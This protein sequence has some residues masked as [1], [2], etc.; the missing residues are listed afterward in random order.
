MSLYGSQNRLLSG[1]VAM[2]LLLSTRAADG[3]APHPNVDLLDAPNRA[4]WTNVDQAGR[5]ACPGAATFT[6]P[7]G[8]RGW[9]AHGFRYE[10][11]SSANWL[12]YYGL[13]LELDLPSD[14]PVEVTVTLKRPDEGARS[15]H[16]PQTSAKVLVRG[17][18]VQ[19]VVL[20]WS[21]FDF[22][23]AQTSQ[24]KY[25]HDVR[26]AFR[27]VAGAEAVD[28]VVL[29]RATVLKARSVAIDA[30]IRGKPVNAG[31]VVNYPVRLTNC[32][33]Q[34]QSI[35]LSLEKRGW[36]SMNASVSP[37][38]L[39]IAPGE[40]A[41][42]TLSVSASDRVAPG[43][44]EQQ[45][46][47][48]VANG[49]ASTAEAVTFVTTSRL[50]APYVLHTAARWD[51]VRQKVARYDWAKAAANEYIATADKWV[52]PGVA[53]AP[54]NTDDQGPYLFRTSATE[55][56]L[57][58]CA[59]AYQVTGDRKYAEKV[60]TFLLRLSDPTNG[61]PV[62]LRAC[63]QSLVQE[64]GYFQGI[65]WS[66][67][68]VRPSGVFSE[69]DEAQVETT[70]R[71]LIET[72]DA[73][74]SQGHISNWNLAEIG[75][76]LF[77]SL[78][79]Q[80]LERADRFFAGPGGVTDHLSQGVMDDGWWYECSISYN[81]WCTTE[82]TQYA[83]AL[84]PF[85]INFRDM[86]LPAGHSKNYSLIPWAMQ[87]G[88][89]GMSFQKW[90]PVTRSSVDIRRMWDSLVP[91]ADYRAKM[92]GVNDATERDLGGG[93]Y[94]IA[95]YV[96]RDPKYAAMIK[97]GGGKRDLLYAVPELPDN[98]PSFHRQSAYADNVGVAMLRSTSDG[99]PDRE[100]IQA[101]LH[102]GTH[103][104]YHGHFD[105]TD[106]LHL[107]RYGR[108]FFNPEMVWYGYP[109]FLYKFYVQNSTS[110][111]MVVVDRKLQEP[112]ESKRTLWHNG[113]LFQATAVETN[114]RWSTPPYGGLPATRDSKPGAF[115]ERAWREGR[116]VATPAVEP[117][118]GSLNDF[119]EPVLQRRVMIVT[120]DY[121]LLSDYLKGAK[122]HTFESL[123]QMKGFGGIDGADVKPERHDAQWDTNPELD[124]QFVTDADWYSANGPTR[125]RF[126]QRWGPGAD[127][128]GTRTFEN[129]D[130]V[131][132]LDVHSLWPAKQELM[133]ATV[134]EPHPVEKR[135]FYSVKGD[136]IELHAGKFGAWVLGKD[137]VDVPIE[138]VKQ[139]EL[140]T[141]VEGSKKSTVFWANARVVLADGS[142]R[143]IGELPLTYE[144]IDAP[145]ESGKDYYG[146]PIKIVGMTYRD[147]VAGQPKKADAAGIVKVDLSS[148]RAVRFRTTLGGDYPL[149]DE[150]QRRKTFASK[151]VGTEASFVNLDRAVRREA[152]GRACGRRK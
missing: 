132:N 129:T 118:Y 68:A 39:E 119:T 29:K 136:D 120:D 69:A 10:N 43:G 99:K 64:G 45:I 109:S 145:K 7:E 112:V 138:G 9:F 48:A 107:S 100:R 150:T 34:P 75:G 83:L 151:V 90:G 115:A 1:M 2:L 78:A 95:Y 6:Y 92:F 71:M 67:D 111:N 56:P 36:E 37:A 117:T 135:L 114:A 72:M 143:S 16:L 148:V 24:L 93:A 86:T 124:A 28:H 42:C 108:S 91:F 142:E 15:E 20:P 82:F 59:I 122:P 49:D 27:P 140:Q 89:L 26:V 125:T 102:Y 104:G 31:G 66:Y 44:H 38:T 8:N 123:M 97:L 61:Y 106:L 147:A 3:A 23:Q 19:H 30:P 126:T 133:I 54:N 121:V 80:D 73:V 76:A 87:D 55:G 139:L 41:D 152:D 14:G 113:N 25:V 57:M 62:T 146:G 65:A 32:T 4:L 53:Q 52:V 63:N 103:G 11:D 144:N 47:K 141:R 101:V 17:K 98:T 128:E 149:G 131:L 79:I 127:N 50:A 137:D 40:S 21:A 46:L 94:E 12:P 35:V 85:G 134:P 77:C 88:M 60:R 110:K 5:I 81:V 105:R 33:A 96:Y 51:E 116:F 13:C 130:G 22:Q 58:A 74:T 70:F 18:G 84:E